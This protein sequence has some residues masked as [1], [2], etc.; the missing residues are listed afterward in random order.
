MAKIFDEILNNEEIRESPPVLVDIGASGFLHPKWKKFSKHSICIAFDADDRDFGFVEKESKNF[1]KLITYNCIVSDHDSNSEDF[2]LTKSP[3]CSSMLAPDQE[4]LKPYAFSKL[5]EIEKITKIK[6]KSLKSVLNE[7]GINRIDWFKT[8]SQGID[9]RIFRSIPEEIMKEILVAE[10]EPG[11]IDAYKGEDKLTSVLDYLTNNKFWLSDVVIKGSQR[12]SNELFEITFRTEI[13]KKIAKEM[14]NTSP[15]WGEM[16]FMNSFINEE[17]GKREFLL[18]WLFASIENQNGFA[19]TLAD[20]AIKKFDQEI[21]VRMYK[22]S[23]QKLKKELFGFR[24]FP[25]T[26]EFIARKFS[27]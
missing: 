24:I 21:F 1:Y 9:L 5:F 26:I 22:H 18:A 17:F 14:L 19:L 23:T 20:K 16:T 4:S 6:T 11:I 12:I 8:D 25:K 15:G 7:L 3:Y 27:K 2:Y 13:S 10:F